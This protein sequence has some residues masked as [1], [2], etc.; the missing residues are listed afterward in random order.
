MKRKAQQLN[1]K[2][3]FPIPDFPVAVVPVIPHSAGR[4]NESD[5]TFIPHFHDF[6]ELVF[7]EKGSGIQN[8]N[9][10]DYAV[11]AGDVFLI[12]GKSEHCF[13]PSDTIGMQNILF[14]PDKLPL[15]LKQFHGIHGYEMIFR[16]EPKLRS[17]ANFRHHLHLPPG[18][19]AELELLVNGLKTVLSRRDEFSEAESIS[20]LIRIILL[21]S[22]SYST[23]K[24]PDAALSEIGRILAQMERNFTYPYRVEE[25]AEKACTSPRNFTRQFKRITGRSPI[26]YLLS[27]RLRRAA[28]QLVSNSGR[29]SEIAL[30]CAFCDSNYFSKRFS[31]EYGVSPREFRSLYRNSGEKSF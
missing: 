13:H 17:P 16:A 2:D 5:Y 27:L 29:I 31:A 12:A 11:R 23:Q 22:R 18:K 20:Y 24:M 8:I 10:R 3:F 6:H 14:D 19:M 15:P 9:G 21:V 26:D 1:G 25:L 7:I 28:E 4:K 30:Q